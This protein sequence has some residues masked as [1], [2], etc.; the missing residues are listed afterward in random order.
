[1]KWPDDVDG[2]VFR[3]LEENGFD[4]DKEVETDFNIDFD[5][6]PLSEKEK[7]FVTKLY[8]NSEFFDPEPEDIEEGYTTGYAQFYITGKLTYELVMEVQEKVTNEMKDIG[9][10]CDSWGVLQE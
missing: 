7:A 6:W 2:D 1:M 9:G 4:F 5:H 10:R 8:P 3:R